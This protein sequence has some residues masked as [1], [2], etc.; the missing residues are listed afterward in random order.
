MPIYLCTISG[1]LLPAT[2]EL[3]SCNREKWPAKP[4]IFT[5]GTFR[6]KSPTPAVL[7]TLLETFILKLVAQEVIVE[8]LFGSGGGKQY[9][10]AKVPLSAP[11]CHGHGSS[12]L[13][14]PTLW[15]QAGCVSEFLAWPSLMISAHFE[16]RL[17]AF[18]L[19][20]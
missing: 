18:P 20:P 1:F 3:S 4:K 13:F 16:T 15:L 9:R 5:N 17:Q 8:R 11:T 10:V 7:M 6:E 19:I 2:A 14:K 12:S